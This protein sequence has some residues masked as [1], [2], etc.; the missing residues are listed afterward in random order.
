MLRFCDVSDTVPRRKAGK[1][2][3]VSCGDASLGRGEVRGNIS[4]AKSEWW[5]IAEIVKSNIRTAWW[6]RQCRDILISCF[7]LCVF[8]NLVSFFLTPST[9][10]TA[11]CFL[12][13]QVEQGKM[14]VYFREN[15]ELCT[16]LLSIAEILIKSLASNEPGGL[17]TCWDLCYTVRFS[18]EEEDSS[19]VL[20][21]LFCPYER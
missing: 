9:R 21:Y 20:L 11:F 18:I 14:E 8:P 16:L 12:G 10:E 3:R 1:P 19:P 13:R 6:L 7:F 2:N 17:V 5:A 15:G 4:R